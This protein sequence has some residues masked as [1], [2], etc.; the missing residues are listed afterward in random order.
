LRNMG[1]ALIAASIG[2]TLLAP[3]RTLADATPVQVALSEQSAEPKAEPSAQAASPPADPYVAQLR[4]RARMA[5]LH[6]GLGLATRGTM[7][8]AVAAGTLQFR[9]LYGGGSL[10]ASPCVTGDAWPNQRQCYGTPYGHLI[11]AGLTSAAYTATFT[12]SLLMP[13]PDKASE[14]DSGFARTLRAHKI[15]RWVHL[16]GMLAQVVLGP[17]IAHPEWMGMNRADDYSTLRALSGVHL[18]LGYVTWGALTSAGALM[19]F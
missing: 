17:L 6:R 9:N 5:K 4:K 12:L 16:G 15:L 2:F 11:T 18:G 7:T 19:L 3:V 10:S 14:G 13:D 1:A 8:A